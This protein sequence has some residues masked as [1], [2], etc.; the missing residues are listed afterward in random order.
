MPPRLQHV[1]PDEISSISI[2][3]LPSDLLVQI[4]GHLDSKALRFMLPMVCKQWHDLLE[5]PLALRKHVDIDF[6]EETSIC[7]QSR[8]SASSSPM[9]ASPSTDMPLVRHESIARWLQP[10]SAAVRSLRLRASGDPDASAAADE[11]QPCPMAALEFS[12][13]HDFGRLGLA[14]ILNVVVYTLEEL[15]VEKCYDL[16]TTAAL[17]AMGGCKKLKVL[18]LKG[19]RS[20]LDIEDFA[21]IAALRQLEELVLDC[22]QPPEPEP[23][24]DEIKWGL[25]EFPEGVL[26]LVNMTHLTLSCHYG[27]TEL[28]PGITSLNKLEVLNLDFC[29][30]SALP[31]VLGQLTSLTTLDVE[32]NL[33]LG[34]SFRGATTPAAAPLLPHPQPFPVDLAGLQGLRFLNLNSCGLTSIPTV[35]STLQNLETLD[36][37]D[38]DLQSPLPGWENISSIGYLSR[39]Q[40]L[41]LA[42]CKLETVP[43]VVERLASL[44]ILDLTNNQIRDDG[45]PMSLSRLPYLKAIGLK[46]NCLTRVPRVL[47]YVRSLQ[48]IYLEENADLQVTAPLDFL[49]ELPNLRSLMM[50]KLYGSWSPQSMY[51]VNALHRKLWCRFPDREV[52]HLSCPDHTPGAQE[53]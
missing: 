24:I 49:L 44:C 47:G 48:E 6:A 40:C 43:S 36:L 5:R 15:F 2:T 52:L 18:S 53:D 32:G 17:R 45:L 14:S 13:I 7:L 29:T 42:Q 46:K 50:G 30:L 4:F 21:A 8:D 19:I 23:G 16:I 12:H 27:I 33:Y 10:R 35:L 26:H 11:E 20:A 3:A 38:N 25:P 31:P 28:P 41:N 34:D 1:Y 9:L 39:L 51:Y 22:D 37:E